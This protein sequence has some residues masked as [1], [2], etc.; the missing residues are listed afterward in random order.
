MITR[1]WHGTTSL[2]DSDEYLKKMREVALPDYRST[3][4][5]KGAYVL[6][7]IEGGVAHFNM[8]TFWDDLDAIKRFAGDD[9]ETPKYYE[10]DENMLL[11]MEDV[12]RQFD[13]YED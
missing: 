13:T 2:E 6:H 9:Y 12:S 1:I 8:L 4:G 5:N 3:P 11:E 10:F 7:R